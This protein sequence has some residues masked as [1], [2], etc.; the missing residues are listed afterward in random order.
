MK[1]YILVIIKLLIISVLLVSCNSSSTKQAE[2][3]TEETN[4]NIVKISK[5][6][7]TNSKMELGNLS[8][9]NFN[10]SIKTNGFIDVPPANKASVSAV[11]GGFIKKSNLLVG[12]KVKKGQLL[13]TIENPDFIEIQQQYLEVFEQLNFLE[14]E[15]DRQKTLY[16]ENISSKKNFLKA[17]S[18]Y[19]SARA[20]YNGLEQK[21]LLMNINPSNVRSS[22]I[23]SIMPIFSPISG[24]ITKVNTSVGKFMATSDV[25]LEIIDDDHKHL[26]LVV[27]EKDVLNVKEGQDIY[28]QTPENSLK[29]YKA[30]VHLIGKSIDEQNRTIR[31]HGHLENENKS[32]IVGMFVEAEIVINSIKKN[33]LPIDAVLEENGNYFVLVLNSK[34]EFYFNFDK[35]PIN[36]GAKN[37]NWLEV[38]D[39]YNLLNNK[40]IL[41]KGAFIPLEEG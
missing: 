37:E 16:E 40:Q 14:S 11:M 17:E 20:V 32:F 6:Q 23:S 35:T 1:K 27:F 24:S 25:L 21:L 33:A 2:V 10:K 30:E 34:D 12:N 41:T 36:V 9:Q 28:F 4:N 13:L 31:V 7:F 18:G 19:K 22:K 38:I 15:Y 8:E 29:K 39:N 26:E 3:K 5:A